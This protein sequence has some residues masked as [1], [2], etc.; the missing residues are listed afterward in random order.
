MNE[1]FDKFVRMVKIKIN[2]VGNIEWKLEFG[3]IRIF[4]YC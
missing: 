3:R 2:K 4:I 1:Y